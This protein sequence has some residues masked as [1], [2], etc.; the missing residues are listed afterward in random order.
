MNPRRARIGAGIRSCCR[1]DFDRDR[2][3]VNQLLSR[4]L[5]SRSHA[6]YRGRRDLDFGRICNPDCHTNFTRPV[7]RAL[8]N[9][10]ASVRRALCGALAAL[11]V[12]SVY[13]HVDPL[14]PTGRSK[15]DD[16][17]NLEPVAVA[18]LLVFAAMYFVGW[19]H[20][21]KKIRRDGAWFFSGWLM[22]VAALISPIHRL[23]G[24][25]FS[26]HMVQ[27]ELLMVVAAPLLILGRPGVV[28]LR[29]FPPRIAR[30][31]FI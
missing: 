24:W 20:M 31:I 6:L 23:G 5:R 28:T 29:A 13:G 21:P 4:G 10:R 14:L 18:S 30:N 25:L 12:G 17:W 7:Y 19:R 16:L 27:H 3:L 11:T 1:C 15:I 8:S 9:M 22:L 2:S 26:V